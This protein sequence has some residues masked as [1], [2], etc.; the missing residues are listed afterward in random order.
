MKDLVCMC[1]VTD[2]IER[3]CLQVSPH[4]ENPSLAQHSASGTCF[5]TLWVW[6][7]TRCKTT[8]VSITVN[9]RTN[10]IV[11]TG[12]KTGSLSTSQSSCLFSYIDA[13]G[14]SPNMVGS[15]MNC[16]PTLSLVWKWPKVSLIQSG[17]ELTV[18]HKFVCQ[19]TWLESITCVWNCIPV[20]VFCHLSIFHLLHKYLF[21]TWC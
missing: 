20:S 1:V 18:D 15:G 14:A 4:S 2:Q 16:L 5:A 21:S 8:C 12:C 19:P 6:R 11:C 17:V 7:C 9:V 3:V 10:S 13:S